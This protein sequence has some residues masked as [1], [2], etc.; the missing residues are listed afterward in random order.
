MKQ[1]HSAYEYLRQQIFAKSVKSLDTIEMNPKLKDAFQDDRTSYALSAYFEVMDE[2]RADK[3]KIHVKDMG[4][5]SSKMGEVRRVS[6]IARYAVLNE[7]D[8]AFLS[9]LL[10][11]LCPKNVLELGTSL[12]ISALCMGLSSPDSKIHSVDACPETHAIAA[13]MLKTFAVDNVNL[14]TMRF[15]DFLK[16]NSTKWDF[17]FLDGDHRYK[18]TLELFDM[19]KPQ[20]ADDAVILLD[21]IH[22]SPGMSKA[23]RKI[24]D[25]KEFLSI[26]LYYFGVL[27][28]GKGAYRIRF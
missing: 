20:L 26:D 14:H 12:G 7:F 5:G 15:T 4:A 19:I 2:L 9:R 8:A 3:T 13:D 18:E 1:V 24:I 27:T 21:D 16:S 22:W 17:V 28:S 23:W 6:D 25:S 10:Y 11:F